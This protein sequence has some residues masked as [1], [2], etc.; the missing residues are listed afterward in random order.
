MRR[1]CST[2]EVARKSESSVYRRPLGPGPEP[3][4]EETPTVSHAAEAS[5]GVRAGRRLGTPARARV[6][7]RSAVRP[8]P[9]GARPHLGS[10]FGHRHR[11]P[12]VHA[13]ARGA[14]SQGAAPRGLRGFLEPG[15]GCPWFKCSVHTL[16]TFIFTVIPSDFT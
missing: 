15:F 7:P 13:E 16:A 9:R 5:G 1:F 14:L 2:F 6:P 12:G 11:E 4:R 3:G 10:A 8:L